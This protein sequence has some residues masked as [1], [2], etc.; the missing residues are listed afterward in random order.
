[1]DLK[2]ETVSLDRWPF[3]PLGIAYGRGARLQLEVIY[4]EHGRLPS[5]TQPQ[6]GREWFGRSVGCASL[7][8]GCWGLYWT[9]RKW[10]SSDRVSD[11]HGLVKG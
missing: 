4:S 3:T 5:P 9:S 10:T 7:F 6:S 1:M 8:A 11:W 2:L